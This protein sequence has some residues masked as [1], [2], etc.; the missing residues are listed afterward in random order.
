MT[1][2][3]DLEAAL[4][5]AERATGGRPL[6]SDYGLLESSLARPRVTL[7]GEDAYPSL[8]AKGAALLH[9]LV[10]N[11]SLV[12]G[13]KRLGW[14]ATVVFFHIN[15][16]YVDAP[17]DDAYDLVIAIADG[18]QADLPTIAGRLRAW[19]KPIDVPASQG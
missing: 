1:F 7:F 3:L 11:H 14:L 12:D 18:S 10:R 2:Y 5:I 13:N 15:G 19:S 8:D 4:V 6:V 16:W 17:D 9:S